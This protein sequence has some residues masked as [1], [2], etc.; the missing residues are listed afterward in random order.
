MV[1]GMTLP[2]FTLV[3]VIISLIAIALGIVV[4]ARFLSGREWDTATLGFLVMTALTNITGF[5]FPFKGV[6]PG[7]VLGVLGTVSLAVAVLTRYALHLKWRRTYVIAICISLY[8]N[9]FVL[10]VQSFEKTPALHALAPTQ[11]EPPFALAQGV[12][13][14]AFVIATVFAAK[15]F[16]GKLQTA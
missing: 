13:L 12:V 5:L 14:A 7:I 3:H 15:K 8:F 11:K 10:I 16:R 6:T 9:V 4:M 2:M 1:L